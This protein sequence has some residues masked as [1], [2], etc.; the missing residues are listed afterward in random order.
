MHRSP[1]LFWVPIAGG[2][3]I[4]PPWVLRERNMIIH[5]VIS[6]NFTDNTSWFVSAQH[7]INQSST[8]LW[9]STG[10]QTYL[11]ALRS[12]E[13]SPIALRRRGYCRTK[14]A[15]T[16]GTIETYS[17]KWGRKPWTRWFVSPQGIRD[18]EIVSTSR[19]VMRLLFHANST[20]GQNVSWALGMYW[21]T[22]LHLSNKLLSV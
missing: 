6:D 21:H 11:N 22:K 10:I 19:S 20:D 5:S 18:S 15:Q 16:C 14:V 8:H 4:R 1:L 7:V 17:I 3:L 9:G 12:W 2:F 13:I